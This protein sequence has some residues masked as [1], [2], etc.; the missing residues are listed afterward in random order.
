MM[1]TVHI[2]RLVEEGTPLLCRRAGGAWN[3]D[4]SPGDG[5][6]L[7]MPQPS[8]RDMRSFALLASLCSIICAVMQ[9]Q[10]TSPY[11]LAMS[12][13]FLSA[14][15]SMLSQYE[16]HD[17]EKPDSTSIVIRLFQ[18]N[19]LHYFG[20]TRAAIHLLRTAW[21]VSL[22]LRLHN[23][24]ALVE[25][26]GPME[27]QLLRNAFW[28]LYQADKSASVLNNVPA[29]MQEFCLNE[30]FTLA[31]ES[32]NE[33]ALL[34]R[35]S[36]TLTGSQRYEEQAMAGF[37]L[38]TELWK[39][40][41]EILLDMKLL[42]YSRDRASMARGEDGR[43]NGYDTAI[44]HSYVS[45]CGI[46]DN[47]PSWL[48]NPDSH[49]P[50]DEDVASS[51]QRR[52]FWASRANLLVTYHCLRLIVLCSAEEHGLCHLLG[53]TSDESILAIRKIKIAK[54]LLTFVRSVPF[55][56]LQANGEP[57]VS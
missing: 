42:V 57:C 6:I 31:I 39:T 16:D 20:R 11:D 12:E 15:R 25:R 3:Q 40:G 34:L 9:G 22:T 52:G 47:L 19:T 56:C 41:A 38:C 24:V 27:A 5:N 17:I 51:P 1:P 35:G 44:M 54:D 26:A 2:K 14:S 32:P 48:R 49:D 33:P 53:L 30:P 55:E 10:L 7:G 4:Q 45:F 21:S 50:S 18:S 43:Q 28:S 37:R 13:D 36:Q 29:M 46:L 23:E 8:L